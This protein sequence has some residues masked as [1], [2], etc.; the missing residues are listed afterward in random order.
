AGAPASGSTAQAPAPAATPER[1]ATAAAPVP[2]AAEELVVLETP[3]MR[4]T[5]TT[6]GGAL[7]SLELKGEKYQRATKGAGAV[8]V[9]LVHVG[10][11]TPWPYALAASPELGGAAGGPLED[12]AA[13]ASMRIVERTPRKVTFQGTAGAAQVT[14]T[15]TVGDHPYELKLELAASAD[16][17]GDV[18]LLFPA[19]V[20]PDAPK[21][22]FFS[23]GEV[24]ETVTPLC[25]A[26]G[27]THRYGGKEAREVLAGTAAWVGLDQHY[28]VSAALPS[29]EK[30]ECV[31]LKGP[32]AGETAAALRLPVDGKLE[33]S[34]QL[35]G[36]PKKVESL[37]TYGRE[38][39]TAVD[40]GAVANLFGFFARILLYVMQ[41][42]EKGV[43]NWGVAI[44][45]LTVLV[46]VVLYPLT[47]RSMQSMNEMRKLQP[48]IEKLKAK[49]G[50]DKEKLN[51]AVMQL[52][53]QHKVNPLG[54]CLPMLIQMPI[55]FALYAT[56]QTSVELYR[57]PFLWLQD[58][59]RYDP[60][61]V[62]PL[63]M[64]A[65]SFL[66]QKL[67]PQPADNAQAKMLLYFMPAFFTFIMLK[68]PSGL[69][70]YILVN[71]LLSIA[72]QQW[73]M[74][75]QAAPEAARPAKA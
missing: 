46:K 37:R 72:Q 71:N 7:R 62:L 48:E 36:G 25:R 11:G 26:G 69:T 5:F 65:S 53:Q 40:Y 45:L 42:L 2:A 10:E 12:P 9:D 18:V 33:V 4:A 32:K 74:R 23:G 58:L 19:F 66:M 67:A 35:Y 61:Y 6:W 21:P 68:L 38:L 1:A 54:G 41:V 43:H 3:E 63:L 44:I 70:L 60:I 55:W 28:F 64:G 47:A 16:R 8:P 22:G 59:T 73:L 20:P 51:L 34:F 27:K 75:R 17:K 30:G 29:P 56:L 31:F 52:Y 39:D 49:L 50:D 14:K 24:F 13:R 15:F 57:E